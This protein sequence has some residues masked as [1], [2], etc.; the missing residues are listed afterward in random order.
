MIVDPR[1][2]IA[3][4]IH[5]PLGGDTLIATKLKCKYGTQGFISVF[6]I[7]L[8]LTQSGLV[9]TGWNGSVSVEASRTPLA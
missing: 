7:Y 1:K 2:K 9:I 4:K 6:N 5:N 3:V 8:S